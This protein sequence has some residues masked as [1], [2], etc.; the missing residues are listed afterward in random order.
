MES[1][2]AVGSREERAWLFSGQGPLPAT[3]PETAWDRSIVAPSRLAAWWPWTHW[4]RRI[5]AVIQRLKATCP[6]LST[7]YFLFVIFVLSTIFYCHRRLALVPDPWASSALVVL[8]PRNLPQEGMFTI[9]AKGRLGNQMGEY[10][11]LFALAR[12]NGKPAFIPASMHSTLAPIFRISLPVLHS[13]TDRKIPWHNYHLNDWME[14]RHRH[15]PGRYVRL[16][17]YPCSWTFYHHLRSEILQEFTLHDH[18]REEAQTFL[19]GLRV[20]GGQP[21]TFVG[22]H[23][24]RGDYV[25]VMPN[26]WKGVVADR[27]YLEQALDRFRARYRSPVFVVTSDDMAWCRKSISISRGDVSFAGNGLQGSPARDIALLMQCNHTVITVGTFGIWAAYLTGGDT[28]YLANF[29]QP[30]SPFHMIFKPQA[31]YLPNWVGIAADLPQPSRGTSRASGSPAPVSPTS[32]F[33]SPCSPA[34]VPPAPVPPAPV[35]Q[36]L[37]LQFLFLQFLFP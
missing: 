25:R 21:S 6:P 18:V 33:R 1:C 12:M 4:L 27:G 15:I 24:R 23:V 30:N 13:D 5:Q 19:R 9:N 22:V 20:N 28:V 2:A 11:T 35:P 17:G 10:A 14:E 8:A 37:F 31:A 29:T 36:L 26:V 7:F 16:T 3:P 32:V 34:P